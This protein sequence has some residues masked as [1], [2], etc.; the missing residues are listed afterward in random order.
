MAYSRK[1][2]KANYGKF[3]QQYALNRSKNGYDPNVEA[4][5]EN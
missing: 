5:D 4:Y 3:V 2:I 1:M